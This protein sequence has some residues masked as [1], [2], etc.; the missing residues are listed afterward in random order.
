MFRDRGCLF[1]FLPSQRLESASCYAPGG[2]AYLSSGGI[3]HEAHL[4]AQ[5]PTTQEKAR[6]PVPDAN[7]IR[8]R[9]HQTP[10]CQGSARALRVAG[11]APSSRCVLDLGSQR[12]MTP[13]CFE[14]SAAS[15]SCVR[16][17]VGTSPRWASLPAGASGT[18]YRGTAPSGG[19][20]KP[21]SRF[22]YNRIRRTWSSPVPGCSKCPSPRWSTG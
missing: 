19:F 6:I 22:P 16:W 1:A 3:S 15:S 21:S 2:I 8:A 11:V 9:H 10:S 7:P 13:A 14:G 18:R 17:V 12:S 4:P 20:V 5:C